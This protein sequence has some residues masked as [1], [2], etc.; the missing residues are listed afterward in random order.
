MPQLNINPSLISYLG[1]NGGA[2]GALG[3]AAIKYADDSLAEA[4]KKA[5]IKLKTDEQNSLDTYRT[6]EIGIKEKELTQKQNAL[7]AAAG[8]RAAKASEEANKKYAIGRV[9][10][11]TYPNKFLNVVEKQDEK[12]NVTAPEIPSLFSNIANAT[13][14]V[15][16]SEERLRR[17]YI[18]IGSVPEG[19][20][21]AGNY[22]HF[23]A[24]KHT[25][26]F[27]PATGKE[28]V[29][30]TVTPLKGDG[31][32]DGMGSIERA[33]ARHNAIKDA[34][35]ARKPKS[36][37][38]VSGETRGEKIAA[39]IKQP[40]GVNVFHEGKRYHKRGVGDWIALSD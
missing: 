15:G 17:A 23:T 6:A 16:P 20:M 30:G 35:D 28:E 27:N 32:G 4:Y 14:G 11:N 21:S 3:G 31:G 34:D 1:A 18:D 25:Y 13:P 40:V 26:R 38:E 8:E 19:A 24:G 5:Q 22:A 29:V 9:Y 37:S 7:E 12:G 36:F 2:M 33:V 39:I 10:E